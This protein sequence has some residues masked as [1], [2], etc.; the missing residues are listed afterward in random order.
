ML[1]WFSFRPEA[2]HQ[3]AMVTGKS[4]HLVLAASDHMP[5]E[6]TEIYMYV[7][8]MSVVYVILDNRCELTI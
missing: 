8:S 4:K 5:C 7:N 2:C 6:L 1:W 3:P